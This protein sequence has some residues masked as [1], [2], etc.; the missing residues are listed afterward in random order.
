MVSKRIAGGHLREM[1]LAERNV[2]KALKI[3]SPGVKIRAPFSNS[4]HVFFD[5]QTG[6][7]Y[8]ELI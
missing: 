7:S 4:G 6:F 2:N 8:F 5:F 3:T 1:G